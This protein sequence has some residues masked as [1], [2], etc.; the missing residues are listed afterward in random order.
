MCKWM[1]VLS[2]YCFIIPSDYI[3]QVNQSSRHP[4]IWSNFISS[5]SL[6]TPVFK[7]LFSK[8]VQ[9]S[10][11]CFHS[12]ICSLQLFIMLQGLQHDGQFLILNNSKQRLLCLHILNT[13]PT[14]QLARLFDHFLLC[15]LSLPLSS[16]FTSDWLSSLSPTS[17][18]SHTLKFRWPTQLKS[19]TVIAT[20]NWC[21]MLISLGG[22]ITYLSTACQPACCACPTLP[23]EK[24]WCPSPFPTPRVSEARILLKP[25][26]STAA[27]TRILRCFCSLLAIFMFFIPASSFLPLPSSSEPKLVW[28]IYL[29][30]SSPQ[31]YGILGT[32][33]WKMF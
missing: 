15:R 6:L 26:E 23:R 8:D 24:E 22:W 5:A 12:S 9:A 18:S 4:W 1:C 27:Q 19:N 31:D 21:H 3:D 25:K 16:H 30:L 28:A 29:I 11:N 13:Q 32:E 7:Y 10:F 20:L 14:Q 33:T 2:S 17:F